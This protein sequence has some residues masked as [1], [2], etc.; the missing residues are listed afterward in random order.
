MNKHLYVFE[1]Y[2]PNVP[3]QDN[4]SRASI[5]GEV[6]NEIV[7]HKMGRVIEKYWPA[8]RAFTHNR[9]GFISPL[10]ASD[11]SRL[12]SPDE[13]IIFYLNNVHLYGSG[14]RLESGL[15][16]VGCDNE[17]HNILFAYQ[18]QTDKNIYWTIQETNAAQSAI[19][20]SCLREN[21]GSGVE[22]AIKTVIAFPFSLIWAKESMNGA[23]KKAKLLPSI[24]FLKNF[25]KKNAAK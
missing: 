12:E 18:M 20:K 6:M 14:H 2:N 11:I 15:R 7:V 17:S 3:G 25:V 10:S 22:S 23:T 5:V 8:A 1:N 21:I 13:K 24:E 9:C 19:N 4:G 16:R